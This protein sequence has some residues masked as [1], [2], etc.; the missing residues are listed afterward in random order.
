MR[1]SVNQNNKSGS[2]ASYA[3]LIIKVDKESPAYASSLQKGD[4]IIECDGINV[5]TENE[6]QITDRIF[7]AFVCAKQVSLFV[8]D[9]DTDNFFKS[10]CIK[11]HSM[12]P[13]VQHITNST[14]I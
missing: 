6:K 9:P 11:L 10:K 7:Q 13:I 1:P 12:L 8:V 2:I 5:E 3:H 14:D 4:R